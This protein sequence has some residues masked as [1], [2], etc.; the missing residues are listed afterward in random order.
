MEV[1]AAKGLG[2]VP[3]PD[4]KADHSDDGDTWGGR[5]MVIPP[6]GDGN[7]RHGNSSHWRVHQDKAGNHSG[8]GSLP[9]HL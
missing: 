5:G 3:S 4:G 6:G 8:K 1:R 2:G 7:G 9:P